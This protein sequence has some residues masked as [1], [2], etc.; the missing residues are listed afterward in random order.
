VTGVSVFVDG[1]SPFTWALVVAFGIIYARQP[2]QVWGVLPLTGRQMMFGFMAF[3]GL[4]VLL[5]QQWN[6]GASWGA[7]MLAAAI[8]VSKRWSPG[9]AWKR[10]R[11]ARAR[12][13]LTVMQGGV[14]SATARK[15]KRDDQRFIN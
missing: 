8:M 4:M 14:P 1:L 11:I 6:S 5:G 10:W 9:L 13:K 2:V 12:R 3:L 7:A 15:P